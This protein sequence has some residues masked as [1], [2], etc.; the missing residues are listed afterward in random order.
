VA[1]EGGV[2]DRT[3]GATRYIALLAV[4]GSFVASVVVQVYGVIRV[5]VNAYDAFIGRDFS[6]QAAKAVL[7]DA[8]ST[9]DLFLL[10][11]ILFVFALGFYQLFI[12]DIPNLPPAMQVHSFG[13]LKGRLAGVVIVALIVAFLGQV[14]ESGPSG[15]DILQYGLAI[16][17]VIVSLGFVTRY[18]E[19]GPSII[20][21]ASGHPGGSPGEGPGD[22]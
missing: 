1:A 10:G 2:I 20:E 3:I 17:A 7:V 11:T 5:V 13:D 14:V 8:V 9:I 6:D 16:A 4:V 22:R 21:R 19:V 18:L 15:S 12:S